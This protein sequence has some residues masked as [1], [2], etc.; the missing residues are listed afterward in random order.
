MRGPGPKFAA[1]SMPCAG[2]GNAPEPA[3]RKH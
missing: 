3:T 2:E 1:R